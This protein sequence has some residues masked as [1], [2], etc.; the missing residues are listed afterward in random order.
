MIEI[1]DLPY[2]TH[3]KLI[4]FYLWKQ[5]YNSNNSMQ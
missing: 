3:D 1:V 2:N 4:C 5:I